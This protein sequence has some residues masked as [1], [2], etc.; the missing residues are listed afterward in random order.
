MDRFE[1]NKHIFVKDILD[2]MRL[3]GYVFIFLLVLMAPA[4]CQQTAEDWL[5]KGDLLLNSGK[6]DEAILAYE[7]AIR[8]DPNDVDAWNFKRI[9]F[10]KL[11]KYNVSTSYAFI[12]DIGNAKDVELVKVHFKNSF[13]GADRDLATIDRIWQVSDSDSSQVVVNNSDELVIT[14][15]I[16]LGLEEGYELAIKSIDID[17]NKVYVELSKNGRVID[18]KVIRPP[19]AVNDLY[20]Y[21]ADV[22]SSE[23]VELVKVHFKNSFRGAD[24]DLATLDR[25]W[26]VSDANSSKL[27]INYSNEIVIT[28]GAHLELEEGYELAIKSIDIDGN[29]VYV[30]LSKDSEV[31]DSKIIMPPQTTDELYTYPTQPEMPQVLSALSG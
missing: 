19:Q 21:S 18:A 16:P 24:Q 10:D 15:G 8:L 31:I 20:I 5:N 13:R 14:S 9:A 11:G 3:V 30:E 12:E 22:G 26:Q 7:Q 4:Q 27:I 6:Y 29:K 2:L 17:G 25:I 1:S 28:T 23:D